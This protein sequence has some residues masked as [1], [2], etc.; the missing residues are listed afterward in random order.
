MSIFHSAIYERVSLLKGTVSS[1]EDFGIYE[2]EGAGAL[3]YQTDLF[4][5]CGI[6]S[7][8]WLQ[9]A[10]NCFLGAGSFSSVPFCVLEL[11]L[12]RVMSLMWIFLGMRGRRRITKKNLH[13]SSN[14]RC[15]VLLVTSA[16][17]GKLFTSPLIGMILPHS[18]ILYFCSHWGFSLQY[19]FVWILCI[20]LYFSMISINLYWRDRG[21]YGQC[22]KAKVW[23]DLGCPMYE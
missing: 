10:T 13:W 16:A 14:V 5:I 8:S 17:S 3:S 22:Q 21:M 18:T 19:L 9:Y 23:H 6:F 12:L 1:Q 4:I 2:L 15:S 7:S 20:P 11:Q